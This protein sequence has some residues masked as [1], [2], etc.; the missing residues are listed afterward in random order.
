LEENNSSDKN[1]KMMILIIGLLVALIGVVI[2]VAVFIL[3]SLNAEEGVI[4]PGPIH[5]NVLTPADITFI[6]LSQPIVTNLVSD[7]GGRERIASLNLNVGIT[8]REEDSD[9]GA[10][11]L[12]SLMEESEAVVRSIALDVLR[13]KTFEE[14]SSREATAM[15]SSQILTRLQDEFQTNL[16]VNVLIIDL[17]MP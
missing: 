1:K 8:H 6:P 16:I 2:A 9:D 15:L 10:A 12:I 4:E 5:T 11:E 3:T 17:F 7:V 13:E 14:L